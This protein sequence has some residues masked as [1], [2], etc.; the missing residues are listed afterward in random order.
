MGSTHKTAGFYSYIESKIIDMKSLWNYAIIV[1]TDDG[2]SQR[3]P[4]VVEEKN[5][6]REASKQILAPLKIDTHLYSNLDQS[7]GKALLGYMTEYPLTIAEESIRVQIFGEMLT[8]PKVSVI[9][10]LYGRIDFVEYQLS[11]FAN[12]PFFKERVELIYILDDPTLTDDLIALVQGLYPLFELPFKV[13]T[14]DENYGYAVANNIGVRYA[15]AEKLLLLNSDVMPLNKGWLPEL[16]TAY[17]GLENPGAL[18]PKL[19]FE[20]G[21]IQHAGMAFEKSETFGMWLNEHP[22]KGL[23][24]LSP[25]E[26]E[27]EMAREVPAVTAA[28][29]LIDRLLY[30]KAGGLTESYLIGDFED[31]DLCLKLIEEGRKNYYLSTVSLCH[32]E[33]QSQN[34]FSDSSWKTKVTLF[35]GW[36]HDK[37]WNTLIT[38]LMESAK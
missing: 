6:L 13:I 15:N 32:L 27:G 38:K 12:D 17:D 4:L 20:D 25:K 14:Y 21:S 2:L 11:L 7:I 1:V 23:P 9:I 22:G 34:L 29:L 30:E 28:C 24:D 10:P 26:M 16:I 35:N 8:A 19:L 5:D 18:G 3:F 36:Q 33:R 37:R 31:S